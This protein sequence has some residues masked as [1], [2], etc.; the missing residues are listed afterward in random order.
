MSTSPGPAPAPTFSLRRSAVALA[1][2]DGKL[3]WTPIVGALAID[4]ADVFSAGP[5]GLVIGGVL[6]TIVAL[7]S[8]VRLWRALG[9]GVLGAIYCALPFTEPIPLATMLTLLH[10]FLLRMRANR[11]AA[12]AN[13]PGL[14]P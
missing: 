7:V 9:L 14:N 1:R 10:G 6:T 11:Q 13:A 12:P 5:H 3:G 2:D 8:G 4:L